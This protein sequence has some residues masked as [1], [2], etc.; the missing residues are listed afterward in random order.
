MGNFFDLRRR[1]IDHRHLADL[2]L[3]NCGI[4]KRFIVLFWN[5]ASWHTSHR[6]QEW[7]RTYSRRAKQE[8]LTWLIV[9]R[10]P[11]RSPW[12]MPLESI[13]GWIKHH[14]LGNRFFQTVAELQARRNTTSVTAL[15]RHGSDE[16][17]PGPTL[18]NHLLESQG[19]FC[20]RALGWYS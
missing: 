16:T 15:F 1:F 4:G 10:L 6:T 14:I 8:G 11:T 18:W 2:R 3:T 7:I 5:K 13:F 12:L 19:L 9:C 20:E 17:A